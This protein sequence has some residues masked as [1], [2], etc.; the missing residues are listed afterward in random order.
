M[1]ARAWPGCDPY[2][3]DL[4]SAPRRELPAGGAIPTTA[5]AG[6]CS[7]GAGIGLR[8]ES[9]GEPGREGF[10]WGCIAAAGGTGTIPRVVVPPQLPPAARCARVRA[11]LGLPLGEGA[12]ASVRVTPPAIPSPRMRSRKA[13]NVTLLSVRLARA[14]ACAAPTGWWWFAGALNRPGDDRRVSPSPR[15]CSSAAGSSVSGFGDRVSFLLGV[16]MLALAVAAFGAGEVIEGPYRF[17]LPVC[18]TGTCE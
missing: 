11:E 2:L 3:R 1:I 14:T 17:S 15:A 5:A 8:K 7:R 10:R 16:S 4:K 13:A 12:G 6:C 9:R 18:G